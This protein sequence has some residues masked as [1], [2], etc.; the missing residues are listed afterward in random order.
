MKETTKIWNKEDE[1]ER[2]KKK[3]VKKKQ[4]E[5]ERK[6]QSEEINK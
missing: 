1:I 5:K 6:N 3:W 4:S 2:K